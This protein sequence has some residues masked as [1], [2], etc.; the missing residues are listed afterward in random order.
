MEEPE[1]FLHAD[2]LL[3]FAK[4][5]NSRRWIDNIQMVIST[6]SPIL[7]ASSRSV[8]EVVIWNVLKDSKILSSIHP[9]RENED[10]ISKVGDIMGDPNFFAYF[11]ISKDGR[12]ILC[13]DTKEITV[14]SFTNAGI[15]IAKGVGAL[16]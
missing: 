2:L 10:V 8:G 1:S 4:Q 5:I 14:S 7:L 9:S 12:L 16:I 11:T 3:K 15:P 13:E 6:H